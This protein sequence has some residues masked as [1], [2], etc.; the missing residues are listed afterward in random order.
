MVHVFIKTS[1]PLCVNSGDIFAPFLA[2]FF[3]SPSQCYNS[4]NFYP[5]DGKIYK[6]FW[7]IKPIMHFKG[8]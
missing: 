1:T 4:V 5:I 7:L 3:G 2:P 8:F 6:H